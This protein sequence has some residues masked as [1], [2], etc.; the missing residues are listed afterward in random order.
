MIVLDVH[1]SLI[2][3]VSLRMGLQTLMK[4]KLP[5]SKNGTRFFEASVCVK[6]GAC[7]VCGSVV[8]EDNFIVM[9]PGRLPDEYIFCEA[10]IEGNEVRVN[11]VGN[12]GDLT[13]PCGVKVYGQGL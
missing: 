9:V 4:P 10:A 11:Q 6:G 8:S 3:K 13:Q 2:T 12:Y 1:W 7:S 5:S